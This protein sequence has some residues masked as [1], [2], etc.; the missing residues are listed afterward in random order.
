MSSLEEVVLENTNERLMAHSEDKC[1]GETCCIHNR[2]DHCMRSF[3]QHW[4]SDRGIME[5]ICEHGV[6]HPD[7]DDWMNTD[8][9]HGCCVPSCC[10]PTPAVEEVERSEWGKAARIKELEDEKVEF[11]LAPDGTMAVAEPPP[12]PVPFSEQWRILERAVTALEERVTK[13]E[14][15]PKSQVNVSRCPWCTGKTT[16]LQ[17][18]PMVCEACRRRKNTRDAFGTLRCRRCGGATEDRHAC[19]ACRREEEYEA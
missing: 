6:G 18:V 13:L 15:K 11:I 7:P 3:Q 12:P 14:A 19:T 10:S 8:T 2:T 9:V 4:R 17:G 16:I 5:R 1:E